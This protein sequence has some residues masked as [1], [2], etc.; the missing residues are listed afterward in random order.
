VFRCYYFSFNDGYRFYRC[1]GKTRCKVFFYSKH[2]DQYYY[3]NLILGSL[4]RIWLV[5]FRFQIINSL[6]FK[7]TTGGGVKGFNRVSKTSN[8]HLKALIGVASRLSRALTFPR[9]SSLIP[10]RLQVYPVAKNYIRLVQPIHFITSTYTFNIIL[11]SWIIVDGEIRKKTLLNKGTRLN[12]KLAPKFRKFSTNIPQTSAFVPVQINKSEHYSVTSGLVF[13]KTCQVSLDTILFIE[14][15]NKIEDIRSFL[16]KTAFSTDSLLI[17]YDQIKSKPGNLTPGDGEETLK[18]INLKWFKSTSNKLLKG[19]FAYPKMRRVLIPKKAG[20]AD[21][22]PLTLT[23]PRIKI[24]ERSILNT[25]EPV[26]EGK[27]NWKSIN[28]SEYDFMKKNNTDTSIIS[29]KSGYFKKDWLKP[30]IFSRFSF[31]LDLF[32]QLMVRCI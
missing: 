20:S 29:N 23:S 16:Y 11:S 31:G 19:S 9:I 6:G 32:D 27:F 21:T 3:N 1:A 22:R 8:N 17:A 13:D 4:L 15:M 25:L 10:K 12:N 26:F 30:P 18:G 5:T 28:K 14:K 2:I 7:W 24:I